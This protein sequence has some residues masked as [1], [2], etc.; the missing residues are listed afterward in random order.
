MVDV[1][2]NQYYVATLCLLVILELV[3]VIGPG[4]Q[5]PCTLTV[6]VR[7]SCDPSGGSK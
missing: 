6:L 5:R 1:S 7:A 4:G 2:Q 3:G